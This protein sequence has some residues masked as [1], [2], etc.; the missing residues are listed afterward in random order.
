MKRKEIMLRDLEEDIYMREIGIECIPTKS[1]STRLIVCRHNTVS[2]KMYVYHFPDK[3]IEMTKNEY[4]RLLDYFMFQRIS[5]L[6]KTTSSVGRKEY[7]KICKLCE[8]LKLPDP[9]TD[10]LWSVYPRMDDSEDVFVKKREIVL[11]V[12]STL[13]PDVS[14]VCSNA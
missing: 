13:L 4:L 6:G 8:E 7:K 3:L 11:D 10:Y 2:D 5:V 12:S 1:G 9:S 14:D